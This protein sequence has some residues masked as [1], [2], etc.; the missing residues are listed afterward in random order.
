MNPAAFVALGGGS[1]ANKRINLSINVVGREPLHTFL[2]PRTV[3]LGGVVKEQFF[4][5]FF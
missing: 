4:W 1:R 2:G 3:E 5:G